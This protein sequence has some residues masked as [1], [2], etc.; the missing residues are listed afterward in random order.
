MTY[1]ALFGYGQ[2]YI[3]KNSR[4][5]GVFAKGAKHRK[6]YRHVKLFFYTLYLC[7]NKQR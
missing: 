5:F 4:F 3:E 7:N 1:K 2:P 6:A